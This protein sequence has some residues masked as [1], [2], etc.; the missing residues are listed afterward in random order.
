MRSRLRG[1]VLDLLLERDLL[2]DRD[3]LNERLTIRTRDRDLDRVRRRRGDKDRD[4]SRDLQNVPLNQ[5]YFHCVEPEI[6]MH[7]FK[8]SSFLHL[9]TLTYNIDIYM[10][11][12]I[13]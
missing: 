11:N 10:T 9:V 2:R 12:T 3:L 4:L 7:S 13:M 5:N 8:N 6:A 1:G